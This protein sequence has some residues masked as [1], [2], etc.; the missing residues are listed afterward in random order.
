MLRSLGGCKSMS[1]KR[2]KRRC[3]DSFFANKKKSL[4]HNCQRLFFCVVR[5][6]GLEPPRLAASDPKSDVATNYTISAYSICFR[7]TKVG[8]I[9][10]FQSILRKKLIFSFKIVTFVGVKPILCHKKSH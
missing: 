10:I 5:I 6:K 2:S 3:K 9:F 1:I 7:V 8:R 4:R